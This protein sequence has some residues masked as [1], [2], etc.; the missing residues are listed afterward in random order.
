MGQRPKQSGM[1]RALPGADTIIALR[2]REASSQWEAM[3][4]QPRTPESNRL[5]AR[6]QK[7]IHGYRQD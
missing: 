3:R 4:N 1:R 6:V 5:T 2:C 7:M